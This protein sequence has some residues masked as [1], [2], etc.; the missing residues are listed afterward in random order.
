[1]AKDSHTVTSPSTIVGTWPRGLTA[2]NSGFFVSPLAK[3][4]IF[5]SYGTC[6]CSSASHTRHEKG[7]PW[8]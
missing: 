2:T 1:M 6:L 4:R 3:E 8:P 7:E 5:A